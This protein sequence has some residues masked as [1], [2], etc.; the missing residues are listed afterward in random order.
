MGD[1]WHPYS[2][3]WQIQ[4]VL[5]AAEASPRH[6]HLFLTKNPERYFDFIPQLQRINCYCGATVR[7]QLEV[8]KIDDLVKISQHDIFTFISYEPAL[9]HIHLP[10]YTEHHVGQIISGGE[11]GPGARP[12]HPDWFRSMRNQCQA[13][14]VPYFHKHNGEWNAKEMPGV[15][16]ELAT[17]KDNQCVA[18]GNGRDTH[19]LFERVGKKAAG[20]L[21]D[22]RKHNELA[23]R[24]SDD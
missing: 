5:N 13:A 7:N 17:L 15:S 8:K 21:L 4:A 12:A 2:P 23:W 10:W 3:A 6:T 14:G 22:G 9:G 24:A 1:L 19:T 16:V 11:T 18:A 20:R